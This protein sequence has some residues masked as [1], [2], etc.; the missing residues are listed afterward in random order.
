M[1]EEDGCAMNRWIGKRK[2]WL[3]GYGPKKEKH[4]EQNK[5]KID[6]YAV[7]FYPIKCPRC[8]S[9]DAICYKSDLPIRY[10]KCR[11]CK[12]SFKSVEQE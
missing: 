10:H 11:K 8:G 7:T 3:N 12:L 4:L 9:K 1:E 2:R 5:K 6:N